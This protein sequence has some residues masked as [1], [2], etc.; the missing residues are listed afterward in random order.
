MTHLS[1]GEAAQVHR[2]HLSS[3]V[4]RRAHGSLCA[5]CEPLSLRQVLPGCTD[6]LRPPGPPCLALARALDDPDA[7]PE[8]LLA[9]LREAVEAQERRTQEVLSGRGP[10]RHLQ[11]LRE[12]A[13]QAGEPLPEIFL[14]PGYAQATHFRLC[15][16]Q[17]TPDPPGGP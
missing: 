3:P 6:L 4:P 1:S 8:L 13:L 15:T 16:L 17:V 12:A 7:Q 5:T 2:T 9:L 10:E 14:D 11:R